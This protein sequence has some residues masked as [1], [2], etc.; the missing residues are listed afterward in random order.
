MVVAASALAEKAAQ[1]ASNSYLL[2]KNNISDIENSL[3][4][5]IASFE[6]SSKYFEKTR[7]LLGRAGVDAYVD[8]VLAP[9]VSVPSFERNSNSGLFYDCAEKLI[10]LKRVLSTKSAN[11]LVIVDGPSS[12]NG[13]ESS[14]YWALPMVLDYL[15]QFKLTFFVNNSKDSKGELPQKW[16]DECVRRQLT[17]NIKQLNT[18]KGILLLNVEP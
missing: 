1:N 18:P 14:R 4:K 2:D 15:S 13:E 10:E 12:D 17:L 9:M 5:H 3:P 16:K 8:L 7:G 6:Q 11:I